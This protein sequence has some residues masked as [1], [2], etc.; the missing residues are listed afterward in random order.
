M[1]AEALKHKY[2]NK[3]YYDREELYKDCLQ[4]GFVGVRMRGNEIYNLFYIP[5]S[6]I[7]NLTL[8][9]KVPITP[10]EFV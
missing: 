7:L 1:T 5:E 8:Q 10:V 6:I 4:A 3:K 9:P 2:K